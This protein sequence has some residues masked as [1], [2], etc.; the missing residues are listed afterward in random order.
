M[1]IVTLRIEPKALL[2]ATSSMLLF[3]GAVDSDQADP[4][5][6]F[7][8]IFLREISGKTLMLVGPLSHD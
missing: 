7:Y 4:G 6:I 3:M 1:F 5:R 8:G 2:A